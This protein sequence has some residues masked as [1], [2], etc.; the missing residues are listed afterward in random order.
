MPSNSHTD[1][2]RN[3]APR[4]SLYVV[5]T[6]IGNLEDITLRAIDILGKVDTV[7]AED[8]RHTGK[9]LARHHIQSRLLSY[10]EHN[11]TERTA[12]IISRLRAGESVA[13]VSSAGTPTVSDPG[14]RLI[15]TAIA[16]DFQVIP[17]PG[18]SAAIAALSVSGLPTD[19][20]V[21]IGFPP[22]KKNKRTAL[23]KRLAGETGTIVFYESPKRLIPLVEEVISLFG[24]RNGVLG[25]EMTKRH[26]EFIRG[27][28]SQI[29]RK[30]TS[31]PR[32]KG[33]CTLL[34]TG[35]VNKPAI[36]LEAMRDLIRSK[37]THEDIGVSVLA[38]E[39]ASM[40]NLPKSRIYQEA[41]RIKKEMAQQGEKN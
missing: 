14:Y 37:L 2:Y 31:G 32:V 20:F 4:G 16:E 7:A 34:V 1:N 15:Q 25:R 36:S 22:R 5:A 33:E 26:E 41:L 13:L 38:K 27:P 35:A 10:H 6:P 40:L 8:T 19:T 18:A 3:P 12:E 9:L 23:M 24:D 28:L 39:M 17:V 11:E 21:F 30:L 29:L